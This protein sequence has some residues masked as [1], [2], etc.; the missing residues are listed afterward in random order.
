MASLAGCDAR[1]PFDASP[2]LPQAEQ[3]ETAVVGAF[4][5]SAQPQIVIAYNDYSETPGK[6]SFSADK[7]T[8]TI[9][10]GVSVSGWSTSKQNT[11]LNQFEYKGKLTPPSGWA[12]LWGDPGLAVDES[13]KARVY[14]STLAL[15][16]STWNLKTNNS[17]SITDSPGPWLDGF[18]VARS[19]DGGSSFAAADTK[20]FQLPNLSDP[21]ATVPMD[22]TQVAVDQNGCVWVAVDDTSGLSTSKFFTRLFKIS[23]PGSAPDCKAAP[24]NSWTFSEVPYQELELTAGEARSRLKSWRDPKDGKIYVYLSTLFIDTSVINQGEGTFQLREYDSSTDKWSVLAR[25]F[26]SPYSLSTLGA[27]TDCFQYLDEAN[28]LP[29][30][31]LVVGPNFYGTLG[32]GDKKI[33]LRIAYPY[34]F[35]VGRTP[36]TN[37]EAPD[38]DFLI[39]VAFQ[40]FWRADW[41]PPFFVPN[42][43][44]MPDLPS[45]DEHK[46]VQVIEVLDGTCRAPINLQVPF[47]GPLWRQALQPVFHVAGGDQ[48]AS[49]WLG[50]MM[51]GNRA[52]VASDHHIQTMAHRINMVTGTNG[53]PL[54]E[55]GLPVFV[56]NFNAYAC[57]RLGGTGALAAGNGYWGDYWGI[58]S[59][60][61]STGPTVFAAFTVSGSGDQVNCQVQTPFVALP[62]KVGVALW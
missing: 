14:Y 56:S 60:P 7:K 32:T 4:N 30:N 10:K 22:H 61:F 18:C 40:G 41:P 23:P 49:W 62:S 52:P 35:A 5:L 43:P 20:C 54:G 29:P 24:W 46:F 3:N 39:R 48:N 1:G 31:P 6:L 16:E 53:I 51:T 38:G 8:R 55:L 33:P 17:Q 12:A 59:F 26:P 36:S 2:S 50:Y 44:P 9:S 45:G 42:L 19:D 13:N 57:P 11:N 58:G 28:Y 37:P 47:G 21:N 34:D 15:T 27:K 25:V